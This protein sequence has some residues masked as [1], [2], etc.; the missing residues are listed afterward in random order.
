MV[1][2]K[3]I[4]NPKCCFFNHTSKEKSAIYLPSCHSKLGVT[5]VFR[6]TKNMIF[7]ITFVHTVEA[8]GDRLFAA[9]IS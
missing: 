8:N 1:S 3:C 6:G 9:R 2:S 4:F 7:F 5:T